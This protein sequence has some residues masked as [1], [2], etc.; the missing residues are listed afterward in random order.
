MGWTAGSRWCCYDFTTV[1]DQDLNVAKEKM[2]RKNYRNSTRYSD[3]SEIPI[4][5]DEGYYFRWC[6]DTWGLYGSVRN[7]KDPEWKH[8]E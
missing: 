8:W 7:K 3:I 1:P 4:E 5:C 6:R 2:S